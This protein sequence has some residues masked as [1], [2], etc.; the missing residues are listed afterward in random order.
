MEELEN[1]RTFA[2]RSMYSVWHVE[3]FPTERTY[4]PTSTS[5]SS[6]PLHEPRLVFSR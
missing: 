4:M 6:S 2:K 3:N 1:E 5:P